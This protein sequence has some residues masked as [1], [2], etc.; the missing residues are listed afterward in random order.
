MSDKEILS[1]YS[2]FENG[3]FLKNVFKVNIVVYK[4]SSY[5][6]SFDSTDLLSKYIQIDDNIKKIFNNSI[7]EKKL[8]NDNLGFLQRNDIKISKVI[9]IWEYS[10]MVS[11]SIIRYIFFRSYIKKYVERDIFIEFY[12]CSSY[13]HS[14]EYH[15]YILND[16]TCYIQY[17]DS[18]ERFINHLDNTMIKK[19]FKKSYCRF[20]IS[21]DKIKNLEKLIAINDFFNIS[22]DISNYLLFDAETD[23]ITVNYGNQTYTCGGY[24]PCDINYCEIQKNLYD[25]LENEKSFEKLKSRMMDLSL[26]LVKY[27]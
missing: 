16:G 22:K 15:L 7:F 19:L 23:Y 20:Q 25:I 17:I 12:I 26:R 18:Y 8:S 5:T 4:D 24:N 1:K 9:R 6:I 2:N 21:N 14:A 10:K 27:N 3:F 11:N 13:S